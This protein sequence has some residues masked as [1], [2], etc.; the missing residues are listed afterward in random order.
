MLT[1]DGKHLYV[2]YDEYHN[3]IEK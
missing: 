1:E 2:S 3:L